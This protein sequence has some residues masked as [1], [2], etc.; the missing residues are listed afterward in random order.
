MDAV[1]QALQ[2]TVVVDNQMGAGSDTFSIQ[3]MKA[4]I[5]EQLQEAKRV[6]EAQRAASAAAAAAKVR[7]SS[8]DDAATVQVAAGPRAALTLN[9]LGRKVSLREALGMVRSDV[10]PLNWLMGLAD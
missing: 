8:G 3:S 5:E 7:S 1:L 10:A 2:R 9:D 6:L 4:D